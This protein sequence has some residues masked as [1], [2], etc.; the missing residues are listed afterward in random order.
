MPR[1]STHR[2]TIM[3]NNMRSRSCTRARNTARSKCGRA[4]GRLPTT[5]ETTTDRGGVTAMFKTQ[6]PLASRLARRVKSW[7]ALQGDPL[8]LAR[9]QHIV[10]VVHGH[11][12]WV[13]LQA[14]AASNGE[15]APYTPEI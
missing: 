13:A 10:G 9:C 12:S 6:V 2:P 4:I 8:S 7:H 15:A 3:Q 11:A 1:C 14:A 5:P